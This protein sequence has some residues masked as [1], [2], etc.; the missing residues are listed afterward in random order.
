MSNKIVEERFTGANGS[1][2]GSVIGPSEIIHGG[3]DVMLL[4]LLNP[5]AAKVILQFRPTDASGSTGN[6][7]LSA[8][9]TV[10]GSSQVF[11]IFFPE[12][13]Y[14]LRIIEAPALGRVSFTARCFLTD[15]YSQT[16]ILKTF[17]T[18]TP[19]G[20]PAAVGSVVQTNSSTPGGSTGANT[21]VLSTTASFS[22]L[23]DT[24]DPAIYYLVGYQLVNDLPSPFYFTMP[25]GGKVDGLP[26][27]SASPNAS[28]SVPVLTLAEWMESSLPFAIVNDPDPDLAEQ[29]D[30]PWWGRDRDKYLARNYD[31]QLDGASLVGIHAGTGSTPTTG[32]GGG[33]SNGVVDI[34]LITSAT[35]AFSADVV[36]NA[37]YGAPTWVSPD[38]STSQTIN[39]STSFSS[40]GNKS[41]T[42]RTEPNSL[43][44]LLLPNK[45][46]D[47]ITIPAETGLTRINLNNNANAKLTDAEVNLMPGATEIQVCN[48]GSVL[49]D[50]SLSDKPLVILDVCSTNSTPSNAALAATVAPTRMNLGAS[51]STITQ[52]KLATY[53][54]LE[55]VNM[56]AVG[57]TGAINDLH[58]VNWTEMKTLQC[59]YSTSSMTNASLEVMTKLTMLHTPQ[60]NCEFTNAGLALCPNL[61]NIDLSDCTDD[62]DNIIGLLA[63][64]SIVE[65]RLTIVGTS[66]PRTSAS[67]T[68]YAHLVNSVA[69]GGLGWIVTVNN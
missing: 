54:T 47:S 66:A 39:Y 22:V 21:P 52:V 18:D 46:I 61:F 45:N 67:N 55:F 23:T 41:L 4:T 29:F 7:W 10:Q 50:A 59:G 11:N 16:D 63:S 51:R 2:D 20:F 35:G 44:A 15:V 14:R 33:T 3:N 43:E 53:S 36:M 27:A 25:S 24:V 57:P 32:G 65:G 30:G 13:E 68:E 69:N 60:S 19:I 37:G 38:G 17:I 8:G 28:G 12:Y 56:S 9:F 5:F 58:T 6:S 40:I 49:T 42:L 62:V 64:G 31:A 48:T 1:S 34:A 26:P